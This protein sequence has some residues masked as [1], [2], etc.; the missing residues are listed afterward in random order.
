MAAKLQLVLKGKENSYLSF[1]PTNSLFQSCYKRLTNFAIESDELLPSMG[2]VNFDSKFEFVIPNNGDLLSNLYLKLDVN[3]DTEMVTGITWVNAL[4]HAM[5]DFIELRLGNTSIATLSGKLLDIQGEFLTQDKR[6]GYDCMVGKMDRG[7]FFDNLENEF[8][9]VS[10]KK[11]L[12]VPLPFWFTKHVSNAFPLYRLKQNDHLKVVIRL[13]PLSECILNKDQYSKYTYEASVK[14]SLITHSIHLEKDEIKTLLSKNK[15]VEII[16]QYQCTEIVIPENTKDVKIDLKMNHPINEIFW[17]IQ[18]DDRNDLST[19]YSDNE[20]LEHFENIHYG[21]DEFN[22]SSK[23]PYF[24]PIQNIYKNV[25][26]SEATFHQAKLLFNGK[27]RNKKLSSEYYRFIQPF[28]YHSVVPKSNIYCYNFGIN[29]DHFQ[30]NG[31]CN[32]SNFDSIVLDLSFARSKHSKKISVFALNYNII[33]F[34]NK[35]YKLMFE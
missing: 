33:R 19:E 31:Y 24:Q 35:M 6:W 8:E 14:A 21:N 4:G 23:L 29:S 11:T 32:F 5:I 17:V 15:V 1:K 3:M 25:N 12:L 27:V 20:S 9:N 22:Y 13:S 26:D 18:R 16:E 34:E 2:N 28:Q 10:K 30:P 7:D